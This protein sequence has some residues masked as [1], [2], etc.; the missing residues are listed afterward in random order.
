MICHIP[1]IHK[2]LYACNCSSTHHIGCFYHRFINHNFPHCTLLK[3]LAVK[4]NTKNIPHVL[5]V[6][7]QWIQHIHNHAPCQMVY[8]F[9]SLHKSSSWC[10]GSILLK[11]FH[12]AT[13]WNH[14]FSLS[15]SAFSIALIIWP[16]NIVFFLLLHRILYFHQPLPDKQYCQLLS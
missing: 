2:Y 16:K 1:N 8:F 6:F 15:S 7:P 12:H 10:S 11:I 4:I 9:M 14:N 3:N 5:W 13:V